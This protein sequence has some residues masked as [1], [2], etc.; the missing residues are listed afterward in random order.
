MLEF[1]L[2]ASTFLFIISILILFRFSF[3]LFIS[4]FSNPPKKYEFDLYEPLL[5][6]TLL[7]YIITFLI[8]A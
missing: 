7:S 2:P 1:L 6:I 8:Y 4:I 3:N 5:Y